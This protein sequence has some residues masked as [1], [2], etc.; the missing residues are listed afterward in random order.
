MTIGRCTK[1]ALAYG[2]GTAGIFCVLFGLGLVIGTPEPLKFSDFLTV[3][4]IGGLV[5]GVL[6]GLTEGINMPDV[7]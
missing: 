1:R 3:T 5:V 4:G 6:A 2:L 7:R